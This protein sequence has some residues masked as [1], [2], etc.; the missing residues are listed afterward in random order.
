MRGWIVRSI[1]RG[2]YKQA[3]M[4]Y[5]LYQSLHLNIYTHFN[6]YILDMSV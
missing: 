4:Q 1:W 5:I 2:L 6:S 3:N